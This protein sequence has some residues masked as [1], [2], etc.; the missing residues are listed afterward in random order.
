LVRDI[1]RLPCYACLR[2]AV[3]LPFTV[4]ISVETVM[5]LAVDG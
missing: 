5:S 4:Q 2:I 3:V 1:E